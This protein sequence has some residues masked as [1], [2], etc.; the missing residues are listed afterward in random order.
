MPRF[1]LQRKRGDHA[2]VLPGSINSPP[3]ALPAPDFVG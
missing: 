3:H 2:G 1:K